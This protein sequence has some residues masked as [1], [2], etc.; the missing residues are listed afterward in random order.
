M[1]FFVKKAIPDPKSSFVVVQ[2]HPICRGGEEAERS[3]SVLKMRED[4]GICCHETRA[5]LCGV[6]MSSMKRV[7]QRQEQIGDTHT[8]AHTH[9]GPSK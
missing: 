2:S 6:G 1:R 7:M 8:H 9:A 5:N 4:G 3:V